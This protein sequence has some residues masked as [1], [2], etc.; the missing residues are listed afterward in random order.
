MT[1][2]DHGTGLDPDPTNEQRRA[3]V[4]GGSGPDDA[5]DESGVGAGGGALSPAARQGPAPEPGAAPDPDG[6]GELAVRL[7]DTDGDG[8]ADDALVNMPD[9]A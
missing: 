1:E 2:S 8:A 4:A 6:D 9:T 3:P 5:V 7:V